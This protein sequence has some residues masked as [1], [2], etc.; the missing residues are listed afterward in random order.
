[1]NINAD[2][3]L[4]SPFAGGENIPPQVG[5]SLRGRLTSMDSL[6]AS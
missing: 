2:D 6:Q 4:S 1:M 5:T 3:E